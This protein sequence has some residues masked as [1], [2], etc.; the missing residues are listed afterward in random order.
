LGGLKREELLE[1]EVPL[2][3]ARQPRPQIIEEVLAVEPHVVVKAHDVH[4]LE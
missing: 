2:A 1:P 3:L 4:Q